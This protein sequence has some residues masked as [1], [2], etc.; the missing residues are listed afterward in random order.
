M[1]VDEVLGEVAG[2]HALQC[3]QRLA[4]ATAG[5]NRPVPTQQLD[6]EAGRCSFEVGRA[7]GVDWR[8]DEDD[9]NATRQPCQP[10]PRG[11]SGTRFQR[12]CEKTIKSGLATLATGRPGSRR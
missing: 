9:V 3:D 2:E 5:V 7:V 4:V 12:R 8:L 1:V 11:A 6:A 10:P